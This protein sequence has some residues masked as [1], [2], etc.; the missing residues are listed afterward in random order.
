[1]KKE[2][3]HLWLS[4]VVSLVFISGCVSSPE[5]S[6]PETSS[7]VPEVNLT[8]TY[9]KLLEVGGE[10]V[11]LGDYQRQPHLI[12][13][14]DGHVLGH[15]GC[16]SLKGEYGVIEGRIGF[17]AMAATRMECAGVTT[18]GPM[19]DA[20]KNTAD[21]VIEGD[22]MTLLNEQGDRVAILGAVY[23]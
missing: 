5:T 18:E 2:R 7:L 17:L 3:I 14:D 23:L 16:N 8:N 13:R 20:M 9:W 4:L 15:T 10:E 1:M 19:L 21:I 22:R 12:F 6:S 11:Q